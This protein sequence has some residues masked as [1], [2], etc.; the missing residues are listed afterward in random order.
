MALFQPT[1]LFFFS[2]QKALFTAF[3]R[4]QNK[5]GYSKVIISRE[6]FTL[7]KI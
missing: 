7:R 2:L 4:F 5:N 6:N 3:L 1:A